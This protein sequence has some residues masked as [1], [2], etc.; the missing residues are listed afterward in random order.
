MFSTCSELTTRAPITY[1]RM[2]RIMQPCNTGPVCCQIFVR[3]GMQA[4]EVS[5]LSFA[6]RFHK[7]LFSFKDYNVV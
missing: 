6:E 1:G 2:E 3:E 7:S 4:G 5:F